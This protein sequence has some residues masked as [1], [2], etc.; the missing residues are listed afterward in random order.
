MTQDELK[1]RVG[2]A[3]ADYVYANVPEGAVIGVGTGSTANCF[4]DALAAH[5]GRYRGAVSSSLATTA[6]LQ[7]HGI[8][9]F[10]LNEIDGLP[11]YVDGADEIDA[12]GAMIK[13]GGGALTRE[14]IVASVADR[15]VCIADAS[16]RVGV[17]GAFPLPIEVVPMARTAVGR[18]VAALGGV[19]VLRVQK[20]G[21]PYI[22][23]NGNE[24]LD[25]KG[26]HI[27][28]PRTLEAHVN[29]WPGVVTV[30]LFAVRGADLCLLGGEAGVERIEYTKG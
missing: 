24:I 23:D 29:A 2:Q 17:L 12:H 11:V 22:T 4:I 18:R 20:D 5:K 7:S 26:L 14:K 21:S 9:V 3:A 1:Q 27:N 19:P 25:V 6:R 28:D 15:F 10:D 16:K 13:G 30:G 8:K